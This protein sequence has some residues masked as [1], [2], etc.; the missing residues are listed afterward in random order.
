MIRFFQYLRVLSYIGLILW[1]PL[2]IFYW[3]LSIKID[4]TNR[5]LKVWEDSWGQDI[6]TV[7]KKL[8][9]IK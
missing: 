3:R 9:E 2:C 6:E 8:R 5:K 1:V 7:K 4:L